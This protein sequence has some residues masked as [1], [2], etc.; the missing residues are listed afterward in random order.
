MK[1]VR[2]KGSQSS[3]SVL[4]TSELFTSSLVEKILVVRGK[5]EENKEQ[6]EENFTL[7]YFF[8]NDYQTQAQYRFKSYGDSTKWVDFAYRWSYIG[9]G[10]RAA[11]KAGMFSKM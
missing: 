11:C 1:A 10:L 2:C 6:K 3:K 5:K 9:K 4:I 7:P 8:S